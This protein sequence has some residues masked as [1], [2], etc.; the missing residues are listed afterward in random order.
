MAAAQSAIFGASM[1]EKKKKKNRFPPSKMSSIPSH[2]L[3]LIGRVQLLLNVYGPHAYRFEF[4]TNV[5]PV[6]QVRYILTSFDVVP[7]MADKYTY[8]LQVRREDQPSPM[9]DEGPEMWRGLVLRCE[10]VAYKPAPF[11]KTML[12]RLLLNKS[13]ATAFRAQTKDKP[14]TCVTLNAALGLAAGRQ[15]MVTLA[16][17]YFM[18]PCFATAEMNPSQAATATLQSF[19]DPTPR[20]ACERRPVRSTEGETGDWVRVERW[21]GNEA[22]MLS[23][24]AALAHALDELWTLLGANL[25]IVTAGPGPACI[26]PWT[27]GHCVVVAPT[28]GHA[29]AVDSAYAAVDVTS[30]ETLLEC[31]TLVIVNAER[32]GLRSLF[33]VTEAV[34]FSRLTLIGDE[35]YVYGSWR[36]DDR[37]APFVDALRRCESATRD[38]VSVTPA[39]GCLTADEHDEARATGRLPNSVL[40]ATVPAD[41]TRVH[42][43]TDRNAAGRFLH[44]AQ[45]THVQVV[46]SGMLGQVEIFKQ[47]LAPTSVPTERTKFAFT[48]CA[49][50]APGCFVE[51]AAPQLTRVTH[52]SCCHSNFAGYD[53]HAFAPANHGYVGIV[54][55][56]CTQ[57][58]ADYVV[59]DV[60]G[61]TQVHAHALAAAGLARKGVVLS[62][63]TANGTVDAEPFAVRPPALSLKAIPAATTKPRARDVAPTV[64]DTLAVAVC[65]VVGANSDV[66][67]RVEDTMAQWDAPA[68]AVAPAPRVPH[69]TGKPGFDVLKHFTRRD[70]SDAAKARLDAWRGMPYH[71][72]A[73]AVAQQTAVLPVHVEAVAVHALCRACAGNDELIRR[74]VNC[75]SDFALTRQQDADE[76]AENIRAY[77]AS[78]A[79]LPP[80]T[81]A[82]PEIVQWLHSL[83]DLVFQQA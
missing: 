80:Q 75:E 17:H 59:L 79:P 66:C 61:P 83:R 38:G 32:F 24:D 40:A 76:H 65:G 68:I 3:E 8:K 39:W 51:F 58:I 37:G 1:K 19:A 50:W 7:N 20:S 45:P 23:E 54:A 21:N 44:R 74:L 56:S 72:E 47:F 52:A 48:R 63:R 4:Q 34:V 22:F 29:A 77:A 70:I 11:R 78:L 33:E 49:G 6:R 18:P 9:P 41:A 55:R 42:L 25:T 73:S 57:P 71:P 31:E 14:P 82:A 35:K 12:T 27:R 36:D 53:G 62:S 43:S 13:E 5:K 28:P 10:V 26:D 60:D 2:P 81:D 67:V 15:K 46:H 16:M 30:T 69:F 64:R